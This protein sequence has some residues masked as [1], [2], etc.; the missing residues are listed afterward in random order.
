MR[1]LGWKALGVLKLTALLASMK[2]FGFPW[3]KR[4]TSC[5]SEAATLAAAA[6]P[7][8][9]PTASRLRRTF[10]AADESRPAALRATNL[11]TNFD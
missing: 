8:F 1:E 9:S 11:A 2:S 4:L 5:W 7:F 6:A 10:R 3:S